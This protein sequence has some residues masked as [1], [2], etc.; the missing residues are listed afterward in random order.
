MHLAKMHKLHSFG[1]SKTKSPKTSQS[2]PWNIKTAP[3]STTIV[4]KSNKI[5][6]KLNPEGI[7]GATSTPWANFDQLGSPKSSERKKNWIPNRTKFVRKWIQK[8]CWKQLH[9][10]TDFL[11]DLEAKLMDFQYQNPPKTYAKWKSAFASVLTWHLI[12]KLMIQMVWGKPK[13]FK[14]LG[15]LFKKRLCTCYYLC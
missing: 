13:S 2:K 12:W 6:P 10:E 9:V 15:G 11:I 5:H 3:K 4:Q 7:L 8:A 1:A 14:T